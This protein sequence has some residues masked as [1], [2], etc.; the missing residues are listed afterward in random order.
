M[1][2]LCVMQRL[3]RPAGLGPLQLQMQP[4]SC[5]AS[6][7]ASCKASALIQLCFLSPSSAE[8]E[9]STC[10]P[11]RGRAVA[12]LLPGCPGAPDSTQPH[13]G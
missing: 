6:C 13:L 7:K 8:A 4:T 10:K 11:R 5:Q 3:S 2:V 9:P 12:A 1:Q